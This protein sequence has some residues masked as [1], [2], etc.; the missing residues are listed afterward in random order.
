MCASEHWRIA[1]VAAAAI[2]PAALVPLTQRCCCCKFPTDCNANNA[3]PDRPAHKACPAHGGRRRAARRGVTRPLEEESPCK[4]S[5][6]PKALAA[7]TTTDPLK[8]SLSRSLALSDTHDL[9]VPAGTGTSGKYHARRPKAEKPWN[10]LLLL[11]S[12]SPSPPP[13]LLLLAPPPTAPKTA[14]Q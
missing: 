9:S 6:A 4:A 3:P 12:P 7:P 14:L 8:R 13:L 5:A 2:R 1:N 11:L 10:L